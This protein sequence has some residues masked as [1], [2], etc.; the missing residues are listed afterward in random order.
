MNLTCRY[1]TT[2]IRMLFGHN[3][4]LYCTGGL[5]WTTYKV[6][7]QSLI[8]FDLLQHRRIFYVY[9]MHG[10]LKIMEIQTVR[11]YG[12][13]RRGSKYFGYCRQAA[14]K[15]MIDCE[16]LSLQLSPLV[17]ARYLPIYKIDHFQ[18][19]SH[20]IDWRVA[21]ATINGSMGQ[22]FHFRI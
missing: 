15:H 6:Q 22:L 12:V 20:A 9:Y 18:L 2:Q 14:L 4:L 5:D 17:I 10:I 16:K 7:I 21:V 13:W 3:K 8:E 11:M 1:P 19:Q